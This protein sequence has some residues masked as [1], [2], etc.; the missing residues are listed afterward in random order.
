MSEAEM[1]VDKWLW[2]V[3]LFKTR[4]LASKACLDNKVSVQGA[5]AKPSRL[6]RLD[7]QVEVRLRDITRTV[8]VAGLTANRIGPKRV[9]EFIEDLTPEA[10]YQRQK[11]FWASSPAQ[12]LRGAGRPTK[13]ERREIGK[14][15]GL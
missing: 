10:E 3:R 4:S 14:F 7:D 13:R 9:G 8:R 1:R 15:F 2:A 5:E 6:L 12:R 11:E